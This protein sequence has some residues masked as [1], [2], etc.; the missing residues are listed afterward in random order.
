[1]S[2]PIDP[3]IRMFLDRLLTEKGITTVPLALRQEMIASLNKRLEAFL[4]TDIAKH[5][6]DDDAVKFNI[7]LEKGEMTT[8]GAQLFFR[9]KIKNV[10]EVLANTMLEFR[11]IYLTNSTT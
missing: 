10:E 5:L 2:V 9:D 4:L 8:A 11:K 7:M 3:T 1:M 6:G